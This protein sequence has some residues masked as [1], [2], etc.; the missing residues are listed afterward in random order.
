MNP[1][2]SPPRQC[3]DAQR[4][5]AFVGLRREIRRSVAAETLAGIALDAVRGRGPLRV[6]LALTGLLDQG[7]PVPDS[8]DDNRIE[9]GRGPPALRGLPA[10]DERW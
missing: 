6:D 9:S 10:R 7:D 2:P 3:G 5:L 8:D 4:L 1:S